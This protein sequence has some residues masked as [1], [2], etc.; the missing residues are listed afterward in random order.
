MTGRSSQASN[1]S[2]VG[3]AGSSEKPLL[4]RVSS[5]GIERAGGGLKNRPPFGAPG[6][7]Q[8]L[9]EITSGS[10]VPD[11]AATVKTHLT[12]SSQVSAPPSSAAA[13][14]HHQVTDLRSQSSS[15]LL[16]TSTIKNSSGAPI[17]STRRQVWLFL[18]VITGFF[19]LRSGAVNTGLFFA[20]FQKTL[21]NLLKNSSQL[22]AEN[23]M[24]WRQLKMLRKKTQGIFKGTL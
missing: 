8:S 19:L 3:P 10:A 4:T 16:L 17:A 9:L 15:E 2:S 14:K 23:S 6:R 13:T 22:F 21:G 20:R 11:P 18:L 1:R 24:S 7:S 12:S 5:T